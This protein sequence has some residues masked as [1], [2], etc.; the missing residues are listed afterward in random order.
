[1]PRAPAVVALF[2]AA[3]TAPVCAG[4]PT[5]AD[6]AVDASA[7]TPDAVAARWHDRLDGRR[8]TA[9]V[10]LR[11]ERGGRT[12]SRRLRVWRDDATAAGE[13]LLVRFEEPP[14][15]R[16][17]GLL[18]LENRDH[19]NDYFLWQPAL[20]R[21][22]RLPETLARE[23]VYGVDLEYLGFGVTPLEPTDLVDLAA[24]TV[25]GAPAL[26]LRE[27]ARRRGGPR[28]DERVVWLDPARFLPLRTEHVRGGRTVLV[29]TTRGLRDVQGV[30]TPE[31]IVFERPGETV[32]MRVEAIDYEAAIP[33]A[34]FSAL[35]LAK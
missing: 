14:D 20:R 34:F 29:A 9:T 26:R 13:R 8:F 1:M 32:T 12:E 31:E 2:V 15:L 17:L 25:D 4:G 7:L 33:D 3:L 16:G 18:Y 23:D 6:P 22:R 24:D 21:V 19:L 28:F 5:A 27:R 35:A 30:A 11:I 10:A